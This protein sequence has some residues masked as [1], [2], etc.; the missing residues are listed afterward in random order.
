MEWNH[1]CY[2]VFGG[3]SMRYA[4]F[5]PRDGLHQYLEFDRWAGR[6]SATNK[7]CLLQP[8]CAHDVIALV[9]SIAI[10]LTKTT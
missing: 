1:A 7:T 2:H 10:D 4:S 3:P 8:T 6:R 5:R 9:I